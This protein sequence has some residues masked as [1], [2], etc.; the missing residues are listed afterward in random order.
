M[1]VKCNAVCGECCHGWRHLTRTLRRSELACCVGLHITGAGEIMVFQ[2]FSRF[3]EK[4]GMDLIHALKLC[5]GRMLR[6]LARRLHQETKIPSSCRHDHELW[7]CLSLD[8]SIMGNSPHTMHVFSYREAL[9]LHSRTVG[10]I[11]RCSPR[12]CRRLPT[13]R[14]NSSALPSAS[15]RC[16][17]TRTP[18]A[19]SA[20][21]IRRTATLEKAIAVGSLAIP[22]AAEVLIVVAPAVPGAVPGSTA[23]GIGPG[24]TIAPPTGPRWQPC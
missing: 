11:P 5:A 3:L 9:G 18:A 4:S 20:R 12:S 6:A 15:Y 21:I 24:V 14:C 7:R 22:G 17:C 19:R 2:D 16:C 23:A 13:T 8:T 10:S 1:R